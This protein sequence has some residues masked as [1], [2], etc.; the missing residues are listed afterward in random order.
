[1]KQLT[2]RSFLKT[3]ALTSGAVAVQQILP[4]GW[5]TSRALSVPAGYFESEFGI[6]DALCAKALQKALARGGDFA[7][8]YFEHS[9][10]NLLVLEDGQVNQAFGR[11]DL[12]VGVRT[13]TGDQVGYGFTQA[14]DEKSILAAAARAIYCSRPASAPWKPSCG[15]WGGAFSS[16]I[17]S[18]EIRT[19]RPAI[20]P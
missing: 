8:L 6:S 11:I 10:R 15:T 13:V 19:R 9:L 1:M 2:R 16:A 12:G 3:V 20:F 5:W 18:A 17:L 7:E 4:G 14:L